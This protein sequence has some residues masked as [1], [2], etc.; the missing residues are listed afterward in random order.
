MGYATLDIGGRID[1]PL[2]MNFVVDTVQDINSLPTNHDSGEPIDKNT[3][4]TYCSTGSTA[5][6]ISTSEVY[7]LNTSGEWVKI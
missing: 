3:V 6:V 5:F 2:L 7:M 1:S 4:K